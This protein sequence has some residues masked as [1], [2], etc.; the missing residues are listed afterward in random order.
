MSQDFNKIIED[1]IIIRYTRKSSFIAF[2]LK[3]PSQNVALI[4]SNILPSINNEILKELPVDFAAKVIQ[5]MINVDKLSPETLHK[6]ANE[7]KSD[8]ENHYQY[9]ETIV[10]KLKNYRNKKMK[11]WFKHTPFDFDVELTELNKNI[12]KEKVSIPIVVE[13]EEPLD[14]NAITMIDKLNE[15]NIHEKI[16]TEE[17]RLAAEWA[18]LTEED[19]EEK[20]GENKPRKLNQ[21]ELDSLLGF[22]KLDDDNNHYNG[23]LALVNSALINYPRY[24]MIEYIMDKFV[25]SLSTSLRT[26]TSDNVEVTCD[27][28]STVRFGDYIN[29]IPLPATI[30]VFKSTELNDNCGLFVSDSAIIYSIVDVLLG[31]RRGTAALRIEGRPFTIIEKDLISKMI[32]TIL[33]DLSFAFESLTQINFKLE[34]TETNPRFTTISRPNEPIVLIKLRID[35][36]DR[37]GRLD[38]VLPHSFLEPI[39]NL[40]SQNYFGEKFGKK[41]SWEPHIAKTLLEAK[42]KVIAT[43]NQDI[44]V[45]LN[46]LLQWKINTVIGYV[47]NDFD[48]I[49]SVAKD[50]IALATY[51]NIGYNTSVQIKENNQ[52]P[53]K[54]FKKFSPKGTK[55]MPEMSEEER[56]AAEWAAL[57]KELDEEPD[58]IFEQELK[59]P[60]RSNLDSLSTVHL[61]VKAVLG[62]AHLTIAQILRLD[63][64]AVIELD[65]HVGDPIDIY[66]EDKLVA[67]AELAIIENRIGIQLLDIAKL[68]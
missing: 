27:Q 43:I 17:E 6:I 45:S 61:K 13:G 8:L 42:P 60:K 15:K 52:T 25:A 28:I 14:D 51:G 18:A 31:G 7:I 35:M 36:E 41:S 21:D 49:L 59:E 56:L 30:S 2:L 4:F 57:G 11:T 62:E 16:Q 10:D 9:K 66:I 29:S 48:V 22:D 26:L 24:P 46:D 58:E 68:D 3:Q 1:L 12:R 65:K 34:R 44:K 23:I 5:D 63:R 39:K 37:G 50:K 38:L 19:E 53:E 67:K 47:D 32:T 55:T 33:K 54:I 64:G 20:N 40:L